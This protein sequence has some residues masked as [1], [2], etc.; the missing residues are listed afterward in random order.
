MMK[1]SSKM[2]RC[3]WQEAPGLDRQGTVGGRAAPGGL[4]GLLEDRMSWGES[5]P[6]SSPGTSEA[7]QGEAQAG[8]LMGP[9][10]PACLSRR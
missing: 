8:E 10:K 6:G 7:D 3:I 5:L 2:K 4:A 1:N 9:F